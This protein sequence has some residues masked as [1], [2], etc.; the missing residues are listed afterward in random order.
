MRPLLVCLALLATPALALG[1]E[2]GPGASTAAAQ[3][4]TDAGDHAGALALPCER[5]RPVRAV[6]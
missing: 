4:L 2:E 3:A 5:D 1:T 6:A